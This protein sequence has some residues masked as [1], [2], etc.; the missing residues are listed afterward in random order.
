MDDDM[1]DVVAKQMTLKQK[2][3][4]AVDVCTSMRPYFLDRNFKAKNELMI[5]MGES[6]LRDERY[7]RKKLI[8]KYK[9]S[10]VDEEGIRIVT[11]SG[12]EVFTKLFLGTFRSVIGGQGE[13]G[14]Q[15]GVGIVDPSG[16]GPLSIWGVTQEDGTIT[17]DEVNNLVASTIQN[18]LRILIE[19]KDKTEA[20]QI[21]KPLLKKGLNTLRYL[22]LLS[23]KA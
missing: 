3:R 18:G 11:K 9:D 7:F 1:V 23:A 14:L 13:L 10:N 22:E 6:W 4:W 5:A 15:I 16:A 19:N 21:L 12:R 2:I 20:N 8:A 17:G